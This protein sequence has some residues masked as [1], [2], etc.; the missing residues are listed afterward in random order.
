MYNIE[1][2]T[3]SVHRI[4]IFIQGGGVPNTNLQAGLWLGR[5]DGRCPTFPCIYQV[6]QNKVYLMHTIL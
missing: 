3:T 5:G 2:N 1:L 6:S 4:L